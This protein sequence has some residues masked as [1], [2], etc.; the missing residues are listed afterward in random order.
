MYRKFVGQQ[1]GAVAVKQ[2]Q[3]TAAYTAP[4]A[5]PP[6]TVAAQQPVNNEAAPTYQQ[7]QIDG[8]GTI[9]DS[10][11]GK[12]Y[13]TV[14]IGGRRWMAE[15][16]NIN[17]GNSWCLKNDDSN[18]DKYG[19]LYDWNTAKM[20]CPAGWHL[21]SR[22]EWQS[23]VDYAGGNKNAVKKLKARSGWHIGWITNHNGTDVYGFSALPGS[24]SLRQ[25]S[26]VLFSDGYGSLWWTVTE[27]SDRRNAYARG[28]NIFN[29]YE[30]ILVKKFGFSVR[31]VQD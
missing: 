31:C 10:R 24:G 26:G 4:V 1:G 28:I 27:R 9:T 14:V 8:S 12:T 20:V 21:P 22:Q 2:E 17:R 29:V 5:P 6:Q 7:S 23:L 16:L 3:Q 18:C 15:N 25:R 11:D 19:R 30:H 13:K